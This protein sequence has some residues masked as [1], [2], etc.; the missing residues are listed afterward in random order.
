MNENNDAVW[1]SLIVVCYNDGRWLRRCLESFRTQTVFSHLEVILVDNAST[2]GTDKLAQELISGWTNARFI[3]SGG[4]LGFG[5]GSNVGARAARGKYLMLLNS[6]IWMEPDCIERLYESAE[7]E[8]AAGAGALILNYEDDTVQTKGGR[9]FD[10]FGSIVAV[11]AGAEPNPLFCVGVFFFVRR[12]AFLKAGMLDERLFMYGEELDLSWRI[13]LSGG[14]LIPVMA[15]RIH[16]RGEAGVNPA[17]GTQLVENR[18]SL[19]KRYFANRNALLVIAKNAQH[20]L[21]LL[22]LPCAL[23]ILA[24]AAVM[25]VMTRSWSALRKCYVPVVVDCWRLR[26]HVFEQRRKLRTLR[27]RGDFWLLRFLRFGFGRWH[28]LEK[29]FQRGF[30]KVSQ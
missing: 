7:R 8:G 16:H 24:E 9:G 17:G 18:T 12:D 6:D 11:R 14:K 13:W 25:L 30:P 29:V 15:A 26:K 4:N 19:Q 22:L 2:D 3:A 23:L 21:L 27:R 1:V 10:L 20:L 28:E 5:G